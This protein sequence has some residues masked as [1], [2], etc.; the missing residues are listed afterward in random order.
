MRVHRLTWTPR[1]SWRIPARDGGAAHHRIRLTAIKANT[2]V[3][4]GR[5]SL[6]FHVKITFK[7][8]IFRPASSQ[9]IGWTQRAQLLLRCHDR[10]RELVIAVLGERVE[11]RILVRDLAILADHEHGALE[12]G[13]GAAL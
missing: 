5:C 11:A 9:E 13:A 12:V 6:S 4:K 1:L 10:C 8:R 3:G 2:R 7:I